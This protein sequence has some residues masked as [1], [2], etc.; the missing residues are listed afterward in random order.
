MVRVIVRV[1]V[2]VKL[3][4]GLGLNNKRVHGFRHGFVVDRMFGC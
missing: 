1:R 2:R 4:L 3:G